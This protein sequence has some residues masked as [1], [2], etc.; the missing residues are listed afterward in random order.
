MCGICGIYNRSPGEP[1]SRILLERM[2]HSLVHRGPDSWHSYIDRFVGLGH[3]RLA[4]IDRSVDAQQPMCNEN[5]TIYI[6]F[7]G[8]IYNYK[9]LRRNL[10][11]K[12]HQFKSHSD[13]EVIL[14]LYEDFGEDCLQYL[15]GMFALSIWD[16]RNN[17]LLIARD[18][19]GQKPLYYTSNARR[20]LFASEIKALLQDKDLQRI[21]N[22]N[23]IHHYLSLSYVPGCE[24]AFQ[25]IYKLPPAHKLVYQNGKIRISRYWRLSYAS[26]PGRKIDT[27]HVCKDIVNRLRESVRIRLISDVPVGL[28]LSGGID[29][30][31]IA[32]LMTQLTDQPVKTFSIRFS[33]KSHDES[34]Y[35]RFVAKYFQT[36]HHEFTLTPDIQ[37]ILPEIVQHYDEPFADP[38]AVPVYFLSKMASQHI[39]VALNGDGG[40]ELFAGYDRYVKNKLAT[41]YLRLPHPMRKMLAILSSKLVPGQVAHDNF[42]IRL[43]RLFQ[44]KRSTAAELYCRWLFI[45]Q[46]QEKRNLYTT[47]FSQNIDTV[48]TEELLDK[49]IRGSDGKDITEAA[50]HCD[51]QTYLADD[52]L[53]KMDRATMAHSIENRSPF[54]DHTFMENIAAL[55]SKLKLKGLTRK[56]IFKQAMAN[57]LPKKIIHRPKKGFGIPVDQWLRHQLKEITYDT[58]LSTRALSRGY[59]KPEKLRE[60]IGQHMSG[61]RNWQFHLWNLLV[62]ELWHQKVIDGS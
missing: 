3:R 8:E 21:P 19:L 15:R 61:H 32:A 59:F 57:L 58:V 53:V 35:A 26:Q 11:I 5:K 41:Y 47:E 12:Q 23:A 38:S 28:F 2:T 50:L 30:S 52:L 29:S 6:N 33:E 42:I 25:N 62:L 17:K 37:K 51:I 7:N 20:F 13:T 55:P 39:T 9:S 1:V 48:E 46:Q 43:Q 27:Q 31:A 34:T 60:I 24:T 18:R 56:W 45:F 14:H 22:L 4:I 40:D 49:L 36:D 54:L 10:I 16:R 44:I